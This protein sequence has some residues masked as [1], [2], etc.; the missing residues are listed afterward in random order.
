MIK[1]DGPSHPP[2]NNEKPEQLVVFLHG[3]GSNGDDLIGLAPYLA[4]AL[5][6]AG[7]SFTAE[8]VMPS[9]FKVM[10]VVGCSTTM[11]TLT[12]PSKLSLSACGTMLTA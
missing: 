8:K 12:W 10:L 4:P 5:P 3:Y 11:S 9:A 2:L 1:L 7:V 6:E